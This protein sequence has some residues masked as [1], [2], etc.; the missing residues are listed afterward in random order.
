MTYFIIVDAYG[1]ASGM[2]TLTVTC[3]SGCSATAGT[4]AAATAEQQPAPPAGSPTV[5]SGVGIKTIA[6]NDAAFWLDGWGGGGRAV[7]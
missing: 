7:G 3:T 5:R 6:M 4:N 1:G 2:Y